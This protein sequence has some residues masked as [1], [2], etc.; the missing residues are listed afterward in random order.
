MKWLNIFKRKK[1]ETKVEKA[2]KKAKEPI[3]YSCFVKMFMSDSSVYTLKYNGK[4]IDFLNEL[5]LNTKVPCFY[6]S[7]VSLTKS[8]VVRT[9][10][11]SN[12]EV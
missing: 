9:E 7:N 6:L 4:Y 10:E 5:Y 8:Q 2:D 11:V 12:D 1:K 3:E